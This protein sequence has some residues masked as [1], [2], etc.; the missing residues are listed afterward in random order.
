MTSSRTRI[1]A[2]VTGDGFQREWQKAMGM[3]ERVWTK[4]PGAGT[5]EA[6]LQPSG[7]RRTASLTDWEESNWRSRDLLPGTGQQRITRSRL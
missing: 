1:S 5:T 3:A 2:L 6:N 4:R 7:S